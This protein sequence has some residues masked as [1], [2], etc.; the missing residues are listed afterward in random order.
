[1]AETVARRAL[2]TLHAPFAIAGRGL[3]VGASIGIAHGTDSDELLRDADMA[4][5]ASKGAGKSDFRF[6]DPS[7]HAAAV[8]RLELTGD[9]QR[10]GSS[11][12]WLST[13][14]PYDLATGRIEGI[15]ALLRWQ[16]PT[17]GLVAAAR[18]RRA[19]RVD[20][21]DHRDRPLGA[22]AGLRRGGAP[23]LARAGWSGAVR[24]RQ[25][26]AAELR[27][28]LRRGRRGGAP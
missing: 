18:V 6:F 11:S 3:F 19:G 17:R 10:P 14:S 7:F 9:L 27:V 20:G 5:Y 16:H 1:M 28:G 23:R 26:L 2:A 12:S 4:L 22:P 8:D 24:V 25:R 13:T 15:E 21:G